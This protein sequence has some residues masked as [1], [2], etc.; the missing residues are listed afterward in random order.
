MSADNEISGDEGVLGRRSRWCSCSGQLGFW[1]RRISPGVGCG[2]TDLAFFFFPLWAVG[3]RR[4]W[5][6]IVIRI[7]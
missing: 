4:K 7:E 3:A 6:F 2:L 1:H 5:Y